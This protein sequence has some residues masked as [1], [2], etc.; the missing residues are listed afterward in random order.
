[1]QR[2]RHEYEIEVDS[3][4]DEYD[5][6]DNDQHQPAE[7]AMD[8]DLCSS[9]QPTPS[10]LQSAAVRRKGRGFS[11]Q[12]PEAPAGLAQISHF[13]TFKGE[14]AGRA[15][16]SVEG[17]VIFVRGLNEEVSEEDV[18]DKFAEYGKVRDVRL[19]LDHRTG[20]VKVLRSFLFK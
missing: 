14:A 11:A 3:Q 15:Q 7:K 10:T 5:G 6:C 12:E 16:R 8:L 9:T 2:R 20:Y 18:Q 1:M 4:D 17:W 13:D 19:N